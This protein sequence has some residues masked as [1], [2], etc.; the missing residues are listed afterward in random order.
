MSD[1]TEVVLAFPRDIIDVYL[2]EGFSALLNP[3]ELAHVLQGKEIWDE[4][5]KL[6]FEKT[7][8]QALPYEVYIL[9]SPDPLVADLIVLYRRGKTVGE[10]KLLGN[11]SI[12]FGGHVNR[13]A[14]EMLRLDETLDIQATIEQNIEREKGEEVNMAFPNGDLVTTTSEHLGYINDNSN[15]IGQSHFAYLSVRRLPFGTVVTSNEPNQV[16]QGAFTIREL[17]SSN[18]V[19][20]NWSKFAINE[21]SKSFNNAGKYRPLSDM[22]GY[23]EK[24]A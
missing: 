8:K 14:D 9:C 16:I 20:E 23:A 1:A 2:N 13:A 7:A 22:Q 10:E 6:K 11:Y 15:D 17:T 5:G 12:G 24:M 18:Y 21:L 3:E 19:F 4:R